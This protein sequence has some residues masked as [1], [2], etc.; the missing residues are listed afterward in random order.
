MSPEPFTCVLTILVTTLQPAPQVK[1]LTFP[2]DDQGSLVS[3]DLAE[4]SRKLH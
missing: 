1:H 3:H 2:P 4:W